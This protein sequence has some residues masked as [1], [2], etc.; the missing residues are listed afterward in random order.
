[1][2]SILQIGNKWR[3][4]VRRKDFDTEAKTFDSREEAEEWSALV[5]AR[6]ND[7]R[8]WRAK[9]TQ[10]R[11]QLKTRDGLLTLSQILLASEPSTK[12][13]AVYFL[14]KDNQIVYIGSTV[15]AQSRLLDHRNRGKEFDRHL[16]LAFKTIEQAREAELLYINQFKPE[17]NVL[18]K[19]PRRRSTRPASASVVSPIKHY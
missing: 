3:A 16:V 9:S 13:A 18:V 7:V 15:D 4:Q 14:I 6:I 5:E 8:N 19:R 1:M 2:A 10:P 12:I 17:H 11:M